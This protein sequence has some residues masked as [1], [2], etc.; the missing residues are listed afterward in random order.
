MMDIGGN[1]T[2]EIIDLC[3][4]NSDTKEI[5]VMPVVI[6]SAATSSMNNEWFPKLGHRLSVLPLFPTSHDQNQDYL[7]SANVPCL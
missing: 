4:P 7:L 3:T 1:D 2:I 6:P 5:F